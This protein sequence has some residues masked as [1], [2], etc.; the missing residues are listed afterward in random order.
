MMTLFPWLYKFTNVPFGYVCVLRSGAQK[1]LIYI[2]MCVCVCVAWFRNYMQSST[3]NKVI[4]VVD[5]SGCM[6]GIPGCHV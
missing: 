6:H 3:V 5:F 2:Y 4:K 1:L